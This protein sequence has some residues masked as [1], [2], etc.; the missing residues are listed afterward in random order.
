M[1]DF[2]NNKAEFCFA[3]EFFYKNYFVNEKNESEAKLLQ[4]INTLYGS[5]LFE[6]DGYQY[7]F[8]RCYGVDPQGFIKMER[9]T[10]DTLA[11][12]SMKVTEKSYHAG[13]W[14]GAFHSLTNDNGTVSAFNAFTLH[15]IIHNTEEKKFTAF[16]CGG[17]D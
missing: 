17:G 4:K 6:H 7:N 2:S 8:V 12:T 3:D 5:K 9:L 11:N 16:D 14:L 10:G 15:N 1:V 13:V